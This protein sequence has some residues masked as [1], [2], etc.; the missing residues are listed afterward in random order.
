MNLKNLDF[1]GTKYGLGLLLSHLFLIERRKGKAKES[2]PLL[3][4]GNICVFH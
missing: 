3:G 1:V 4:D 2:S